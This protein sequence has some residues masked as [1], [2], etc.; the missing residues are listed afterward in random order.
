VLGGS[1]AA[2]CAEPAGSTQPLAA[3]VRHAGDAAALA[4]RSGSPPLDGSARTPVRAPRANAIAERWIAT[5]RRELLD[6]ILIADQRQLEHVLAVF[7]DHYNSH[8][9]TCRVPPDG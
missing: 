4:P 5:L 9:A 1:G 7:V 8:D 6:R 3:A 2:G